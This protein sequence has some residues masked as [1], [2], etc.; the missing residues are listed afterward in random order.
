M[1]K[2]DLLIDHEAET[3]DD[4]VGII[5]EVETSHV[6]KCTYVDVLYPIGIYEVEIP[7][8]DH[9]SSRWEVISV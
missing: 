6:N 8:G 5:L 1:K 7:I 3:D 2:D 9:L 4:K